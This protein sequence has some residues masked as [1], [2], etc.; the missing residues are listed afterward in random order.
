[1]SPAT[2]H[3]W[4]FKPRFRRESFGWKSQPAIQRIKEAVA[5]I[6]KVARKDPTLAAEGAVLFLERLAPAIDRVDGSSGS[7][8]TA[9]NNA[10][11]TLTVMIAAAPA[12]P[13]TREDWLSRLWKACEDDGKPYLERLGD[14][15]GPLC[16]SK[17]VASRWADELAP[18]LRAM[19][20]P[21][22]KSSGYY[23]GTNACFSALLAAERHAEILDLLERAPHVW[24]HYRR[25]GVQALAA[26]GKTDAA[27]AYADAS[28]GFNDDPRERAPLCESI[29]LAAGRV[30]EAYRRFGV[31]AARA[32]TYIATFR[33]LA[34]RYPS[35]PPQQLL[36]DLAA[37]SPGD[38]GKWFA[39]ARDVGLHDQALELARRSP[40]APKTLIHAA[41]EEL[42][43]R[44]V[45]AL[46]VG[47]LALHWIV[48]GYGYDITGYDVLAAYNATMKAAEA[49]GR[50]DESF[51]RVRALV[52]SETFGERFV[53]KILKRELR[54]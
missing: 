7:I 14:V 29:L 30:D 11:T 23:Q 22:E 13:A 53:T 10:I 16:A 35:K 15:W 54:L 38:E 34:K 1:M 28:Q 6:K 45:F 3:V 27:L 41:T 20:R 2:G 50:R 52:A 37:S 31:L 5:E 12:D 33:A 17:P 9:V 19:W 32:S 18:V 4:E 46:E 48:E 24:W 26:M 40:G 36:A 21:G 47:Y 25:W 8:S 49:L 43:E 44:P 51:A 39:A 42:A